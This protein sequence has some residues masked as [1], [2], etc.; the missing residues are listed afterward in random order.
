[1]NGCSLLLYSSTIR[2]LHSK[3]LSSC[4]LHHILELHQGRVC[5][6]CILGL[7]CAH[8]IARNILRRDGRKCIVNV[9]GLRGRNRCNH[10]TKSSVDRLKVSSR[11]HTL[12]IHAAN[13]FVVRQDTCLQSCG[14][15]CCTH[16]QSLVHSLEHLGWGRSWQLR[17]DIRVPVDLLQEWVGC[18]AH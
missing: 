13:G 15:H 4:R 8:Q 10:V 2:R 18:R 16:D 14:V 3:A 7:H 6:L 5:L 17:I 11:C 1:M 12:G 9:H